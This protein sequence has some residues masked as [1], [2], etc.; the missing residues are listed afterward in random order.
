AAPLR[1]TAA[2]RI[3]SRSRNE[4]RQRF[5]AALRS[6]DDA[7]ILLA[8]ILRRG[9]G[10]LSLSQAVAETGWRGEE[11]EK[12]AAALAAAKQIARAGE[13]L[14]STPALSALKDAA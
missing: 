10:G 3:S 4:D 8:R 1:A 5:F 7:N 13:L 14:V 6:G 9:A 11:L 2:K 12:V